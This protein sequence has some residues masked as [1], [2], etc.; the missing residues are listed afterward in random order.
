MRA[1]HGSETP[2]LTFGPTDL[3][4]TTIQFTKVGFAQ[5]RSQRYV[6]PKVW[7]DTLP[8]N[9]T[10][11]VSATPK[12]MGETEMGMKLACG[13]DMLVSDPQKKSSKPV[14]E[15]QLLIDDIE[16]GEEA[17]PTDAEIA[18]WWTAPPDSE[19][20]LDIDYASFEKE[21]S[22]GGAA[23]VG[24]EAK[25]KK[26]AGPN[27]AAGTEGFGDKAAQENLRKMVQRFEAFLN[28]DKAG[29]EGAEFSDDMDMDDDDDDDD[30]DDTSDS[31]EDRDVSFDE[32]EFG[33]IMREMMGFP[34]GVPPG[35][36]A[37]TTK[38]MPQTYE[39]ESDDED[40]GDEGSEYDDSENEGVAVEREMNA[41]EKELKGLGALNLNPPEQ[42]TEAP[43][44]KGKG[45]EAEK[46]NGDDVQSEDDSDAEVD[47]DF[48]LAKNML[49]SLK[50]QG[51]LAGPAGNM[52]GLMGISMPPDEDENE[53]SKKK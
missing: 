14:R 44:L 32:A 30:E 12:I 11:P 3:I 27:A 26:A 17:L 19:A 53:K 46:V 18:R 40:S 24:D 25:A 9:A 29:V 28:D 47:V 23:A 15:I 48:N 16:S 43:R 49:E 52:M 8:T 45:K 2:N 6:P 5:M 1:L 22:G 21:L 13:F 20:W 10:P 31:E 39:E 41:I 35:S 33:R 4:V 37:K 36:I 50:G 42:K 34:A 7:A 51:G 38:N